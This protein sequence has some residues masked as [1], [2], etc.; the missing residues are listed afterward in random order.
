MIEATASAVNHLKRLLEAKGPSSGLG[1]RLSVE[2]G[3]CAGWQYAMNIT[4]RAENDEIIECDG[5]RFFVA[6]DSLSMLSGSRIDYEDSLHDS[7]FKISN[8][9]AARSCGCGTS[10][11]PTPAGSG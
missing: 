5:V 9:N 7:G 4:E 2:K 3:G 11:E 10:F 8:P 1:L 6:K